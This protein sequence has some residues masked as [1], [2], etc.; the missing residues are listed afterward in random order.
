MAGDVLQFIWKRFLRVFP[1][2]WVALVVG[3]LAVGPLI[4][5][6]EGRRL[7]DYFAVGQGSPYHYL[8]TNFDLSIEAFS[9][10]D[11]FATTT[12]YGVAVGSGGVLN[13]SL[14]TLTYEWSSYLVVGVLLGL[15]LLR[16]TRLTVLA[17]AVLFGVANV[18][19]A[20]QPNLASALFGSVINSQFA[21]FGFVF[22]VGAS[23]AAY[24]ESIR[25]TLPRGI[26][27]GVIVVVSLF[28]PAW[29][30]VGYA[31]LPYFLMWVATVLPAGV[32]WIGQKNDFSYGVYLYGF[33]VQQTTAYFGLHYLGI[34]LWQ[35]ITMV[36][37]F[38][39]AWLSWTFIE[40]PSLRLKDFGPGR[41][42]KH[43]LGRLI[44]R[45]RQP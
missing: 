7:L 34:T 24:G 17:S 28:T 35:I 9:V 41:G 20:V 44:P 14:W 26:I 12:P 33:L 3:A 38:G 36:L 4:W 6:S 19:Y 43:W 10:W 31:V 42:L 25:L 8:S 27:S 29:E 16:F 40:K 30:F 11:I 15:G 18:L 32:Q 45:R 39:L 37:A 5:L 22:L 1:G 23:L 21:S 13:G 2:Y